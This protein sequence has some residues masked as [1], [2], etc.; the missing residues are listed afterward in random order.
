[1]KITLSLLTITLLTGCAS[2]RQEPAPRPHAPQ[3]TGFLEKGPTVAMDT[4]PPKNTTL[5]MLDEKIKENAQLKGRIETTNAARAEA[6]RRA[7]EAEAAAGRHTARIA[8]LELLLARQAEE[9]KG[10]MDEL[11][12]ARITRLRMERQLLQG[13]LADLADEKK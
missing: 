5:Q 1:M 9:N 6:E 8:E 12:K 2:T 7:A 10:L 11:L 3:G 13:R 4:K